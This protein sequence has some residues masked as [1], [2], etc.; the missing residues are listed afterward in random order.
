[1]PSRRWCVRTAG[2]HS[3]G[4]CSRR[5]LARAAPSRPLV[6]RQR[7][8]QR[9]AAAQ[10]G[11]ADDRHRRRKAADQ[12][13]GVDVDADQ[14]AVEA[15]RL[16][17]GVHLG[18]AELGADREHDVGR[19]QRLAQR[20]PGHVLAGVQRMAGRQDALGVDGVDHRQ[21]RA[22]RP[23]PRPRPPPP[24]APPPSTIS[25]RSAPRQ[26]RR[27]ARDRVAGRAPGGPGRG[28]GCQRQVVAGCGD[29]VD[30]DLDVH[31]PRPRA[32]EQREGPRQHLGQLARVQHGVAE[33][34]DAC[35]HGLLR[36]QLV[37]PALA[38]RQLLG[39]V[40][41]GD[42]QHRD[43]IAIGLA[44][45]G[46]DVGHAG[47]G[48]DEADARLAADPGIAVGHEAGALLVARRDVPDPGRR[49]AAIELDRVHA[50][51]AE[52]RVDPVALEQPHQHFAAGGH[53]V[54]LRLGR[55]C[56]RARS[57]RPPAAASRRWRRRA[58]ARSR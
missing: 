40:D 51:D 2:H 53:V 48:D 13:L 14:L 43:R 16:R 11:V 41:A 18:L 49:Q 6:G 45:R 27:R 22:A 1:M 8:Q 47:A 10:P 23:A 25:G 52:H 38:H 58:P 42:H 9:R 31:R 44:H 55:G 17:A 28:R 24:T 4:S 5:A 46:Q 36:A 7:R 32:G 29:H 21:R 35:H 30:R 54:L 15:Q 56:G 12:L 19:A 37:Q 26:Q 39:A 34:G 50:R 33:G 57:G 3:G 20:R